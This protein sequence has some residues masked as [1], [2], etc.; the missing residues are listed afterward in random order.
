MGAARSF[1]QPL[2]CSAVEMIGKGAFCKVFERT[3]RGGHLLSSKEL[4]SNI[5]LSAPP[6]RSVRKPQGYRDPD[7]KVAIQ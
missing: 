4:D 7:S 1:S 2:D 6:P 3:V 5:C